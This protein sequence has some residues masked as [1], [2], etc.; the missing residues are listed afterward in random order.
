MKKMTGE[1][2]PYHFEW[3]KPLFKMI[4]AQISHITDPI[5]EYIRKD[6]IGLKS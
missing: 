1:I 4:P 2:S 5:Y 3:V 6:F